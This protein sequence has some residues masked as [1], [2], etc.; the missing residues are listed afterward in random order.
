[1]KDKLIKALESV[2]DEESFISFVAVLAEDKAE[3]NK[4]ENSNPSSTFGKGANG[5]ENS[6]IED[7]L[8]AAAEWAEA[9][10]ADLEH[11][12]KPDNVWR[13]CADILYAGKIYE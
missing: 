11:Y 5:W 2:E 4:E 7:F 12:Q 3:E 8:V 9:S 13:R 10:Q 6:R 1:M